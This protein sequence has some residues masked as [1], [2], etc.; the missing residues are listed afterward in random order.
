MSDTK[1]WTALLYIP[2]ANET[3]DRLGNPFVFFYPFLI[4]S[5]QLLSSIIRQYDSQDLLRKKSALTFSLLCSSDKCSNVSCALCSQYVKS[6]ISCSLCRWCSSIAPPASPEAR[7]AYSF[8]FMLC[9]DQHEGMVP[10]RAPNTLV[11]IVNFF[12]A[13]SSTL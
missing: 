1:Q 5:S 6:T 9:D 2:V 3:L 13:V 12:T 10:Q 7:D 11:L 8:F 4:L